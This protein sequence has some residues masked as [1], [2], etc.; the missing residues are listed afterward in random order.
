M[1]TPLGISRFS[2]GWVF[3]ELFAAAYFASTIVSDS[4]TYGTIGVVFSLMTWFIAVGA[5]VVLGT[6][7][8]ATWRERRGR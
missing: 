7:L 8:G 2:L 3:L 4:R 5:V 1:N 6:A